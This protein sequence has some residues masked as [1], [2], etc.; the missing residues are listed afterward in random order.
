MEFSKEQLR[1]VQHKSIVGTKIRGR[2]NW[3]QQSDKGTKFFF[4]MLKQKEYRENID[5]LWVEGIEIMDGDDIKKKFVAFYREL[6]TFEE[7][8]NIDSAR[9][10]CKKIIPQWVSDADA[11]ELKKLISTNEIKKFN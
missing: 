9:L 11:H 10:I 7:G 8:P 4:N 2:A 6:F 1:K 3:L 5:C